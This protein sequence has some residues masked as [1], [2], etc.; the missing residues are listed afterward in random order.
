MTDAFDQLEAE[1]EATHPDV[2]IR[3][4]VAGSNTLLRQIT[5]GADAD[6]FASADAQLLEGWESS[7]IAL[8]AL[9]AVVPN[10]SEITRA[11]EL[12]GSDITT[13]RCAAGVPC[14]DLLDDLL[15][16]QDRSLSRASIESNVRA[17]LTKVRLGVV[18]GGFVYATDAVSAS[19]EVVMLPLDVTTLSTSAIALLDPDDTNAQTFVDYVLSAEGAEIFAELGF[20][21][22]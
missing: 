9:V 10:D 15:A 3:V 6:I 22:P 1:F 18:D 13:A 8:N 16:Q 14:G 20:V 12:F 4:T 5:D 19:D 7:D 11:D 17:V 21:R 2:N